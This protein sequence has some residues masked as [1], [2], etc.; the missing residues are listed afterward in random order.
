MNHMSLMMSPACD[1]AA[2]PTLSKPIK[3]GYDNVNRA[4]FAIATTKVPGQPDRCI[5]L[6]EVQIHFSDRVN[7]AYPAADMFQ[8][9]FR[10]TEN[11]D[12]SPSG[13]TRQVFRVR[14]S[15]TGNKK[16][17]YDNA[18]YYNTIDLRVK[19]INGNGL[20]SGWSPI[21]V[22]PGPSFGEP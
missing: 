19:A 11:T 12:V 5:V 8:V 13:Q 17:L 16:H 22:V 6:Y 4:T 15:D 14:A 3:A 18:K 21:I 20:T 1:A 9:V 2:F 7:P 10:N